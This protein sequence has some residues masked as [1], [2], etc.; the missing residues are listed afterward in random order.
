[1]RGPAQCSGLNGINF[2][3]GGRGPGDIDEVIVLD[4]RD[5]SGPD[6]S[7]WQVDCLLV[8]C[9]APTSYH[10]QELRY[11]VLSPRFKGVPVADLRRDGGFVAVGRILS[12]VW[13]SRPQQF[14][15]NQVQ[16]WE[17]QRWRCSK[18]LG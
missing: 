9:V 18:V 5:I 10:G 6:V 17:L 1:M 16:Y 4:E 14:D 2:Q 13:I 12:G 11:L 8:R 7:N 15:P 3:G